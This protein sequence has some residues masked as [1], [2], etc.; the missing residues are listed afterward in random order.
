MLLVMFAGGPN[1]EPVGPQMT[2]LNAFL[3]SPEGNF[4]LNSEAPGASGTLPHLSLSGGSYSV[5]HV[6]QEPRFEVGT[7]LL[8]CTADLTDGDIDSLSSKLDSRLSIEKTQN[9]EAQQPGFTRQTSQLHTPDV[10]SISVDGA[11]SSVA[12][13]AVTKKNNLNK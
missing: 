11:S 10:S 12:A 8:Y 7:V 13:V 1:P 2:N 6:E 9:S 4:L 3:Q 5:I